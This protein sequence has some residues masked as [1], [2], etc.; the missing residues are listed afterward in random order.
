MS[1]VVCLVPACHCFQ[2]AAGLA[3]LTVRAAA[4]GDP[5]DRL[6]QLCTPPG[7]MG[8]P[9]S[10]SLVSPSSVKCVKDKS[11]ARKEKCAAVSFTLNSSELFSSAWIWNLVEWAF[12]L[13]AI[14]IVRGPEPQSSC[15]HKTSIR[16]HF[17]DHYPVTLKRKEDSIPFW[18]VH[19]NLIVSENNFPLVGFTSEFNGA[20]GITVLASETMLYVRKWRPSEPALPM[21]D[22]APGRSDRYREVTAV[23]AS[24]AESWLPPS[25]L[26]SPL[27]SD[28]GVCTPAVPRV[29]SL[30]GRVLVGIWPWLVTLSPST[31]TNS[32]SQHSGGWRRNFNE[33]TL[34]CTS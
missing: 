34:I 18:N 12:L 10:M 14:L 25:G 8:A 20:T 29:F 11:R 7:R 26:R 21:P 15:Q 17:L 23:R 16:F 13:P 9:R 31:N 1:G 19:L 33:H 32:T 5:R 6:P 4:G 24:L 2:S 27:M 28:G 22:L 30:Q 3:T